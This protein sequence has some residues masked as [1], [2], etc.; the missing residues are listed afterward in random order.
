MLSFKWVN[1]VFVLTVSLSLVLIGFE[2]LEYWSLLIVIVLYLFI[3]FRGVT[4]IEK[5]FFIDS[6][7]HLSD[8][9]RVLL[10]FDDGPHPEHTPQIL[11]MLDKYQVKAVFFVIGKNAEK[12]P[13]LLKDIHQRGHIIAN[14]SYSHDSLFDVFSTKK[15]ISD[16]EQAQM[17][18]DKTLGFKP[19]YFRPPFGITN[20]RIKRLIKHTSLISVAWSFRSYDTGK[21]TNDQIFSRLKQEIKGG[22]IL[23]FHD[24]QERT[25]GLM[26][27]V[28]P[29][30]GENYDITKNDLS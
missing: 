21:Q 16:V 24:T 19:V 3:L 6:I 25:L 26:E 12:H 10:T 14:H 4:Q 13:D 30:L 17:V 7:N 1:I 23:L 9:K 11:R 15:M 29:W 22:D 2:K 27:L 8:S 28:L 18:I 5:N 20:P